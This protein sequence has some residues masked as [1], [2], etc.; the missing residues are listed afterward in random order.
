MVRLRCI[1]ARAWSHLRDTA[2]TARAIRAAHDARDRANGGDDL[3]DGIG[4]EFSFDQARQARCNGSAYL[5]LGHATEDGSRST[6]KPTPISPVPTCWR[7]N[8]MGRR[9]RS[10]PSLPSPQSIESKA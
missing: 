4:G 5:E 3:H 2:E 10:P 8:S 6:P 9:R 7:A 1:E